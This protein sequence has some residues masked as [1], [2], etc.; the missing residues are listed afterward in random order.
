MEWIFGVKIQ[1]LEVLPD[2]YT[3][4]ITTA[5]DQTYEARHLSHLFLLFLSIQ[6]GA[7]KVVEFDR[8]RYDDELSYASYRT[9]TRPRIRSEDIV[10]A[11]YKQKKLIYHHGK[12]YGLQKLE[13]IET[14]LIDDNEE[15]V[16]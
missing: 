6:T 9:N 3:I 10:H 4:Y 15:P 14:T 12:G 2:M 16:F 13:D 7:R 5:D 11:P 8:T 1:S